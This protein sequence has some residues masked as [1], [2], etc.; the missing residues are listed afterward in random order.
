[1]QLLQLSFLEFIL[2]KCCSIPLNLYLGFQQ[3]YL[4]KL[5]GLI[6]FSV[7]SNSFVSWV[8][9]CIVLPWCLYGPTV[10][11]TR[12]LAQC[13][14]SSWPVD[15]ILGL[16]P[17][18]CDSVLSCTR[19][20]MREVSRSEW[21]LPVNLLYEK[22]SKYLSLSWPFIPRRAEP[23]VSFSFTAD[24]LLAYKARRVTVGFSFTP[25][26]PASFASVSNR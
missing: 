25:E 2:F 21:E 24:C 23:A 16:A 5:P 4:F 22:L 14:C 12:E 13:N 6:S 26:W 10:R 9:L 19:A 11:Q 3:L 1:M 7:L 8:S 15:F 18:V 20:R 17:P